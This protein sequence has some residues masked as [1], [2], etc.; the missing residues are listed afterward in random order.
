MPHGLLSIDSL[1]TQ[2]NAKRVFHLL[3]TLNKHAPPRF[4]KN[5]F[6]IRQNAQRQRV[7][8]RLGRG[9]AKPPSGRAN[10]CVHFWSPVVVHGISHRAEPELGVLAARLV[11]VLFVLQVSV[12]TVTEGYL[13]EWRILPFPPRKGDDKAGAVNRHSARTNRSWLNALR[14]PPSPL[15]SFYHAEKPFLG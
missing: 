6:R 8:A 5:F 2:A 12:G 3:S 13:P 14:K 11:V 1:A 15:A 7:S 9:Q 10:G 4:V